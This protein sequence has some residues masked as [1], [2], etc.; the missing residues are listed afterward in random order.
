MFK[1]SYRI[2]GL[3]HWKSLHNKIINDRSIIISDMSDFLQLSS[4]LKINSRYVLISN[5]NRDFT[6]HNINPFIFPNIK[7]LYLQSHP[8]S[9]EYIQLWDK[10]ASE[11]FHGYINHK[12]KAFIKDTKR[13]NIVYDLD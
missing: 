13:W 9:I 12:Y 6:F 2:S 1:Y 10:Y 8:Y 11:N 4:P 5:C 3:K 7:K